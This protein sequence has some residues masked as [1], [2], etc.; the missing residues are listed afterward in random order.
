M[1]SSFPGAGVV[2]PPAPAPSDV[3]ALR[4][5]I[6]EHLAQNRELIAYHNRRAIRETER[7]LMEQTKGMHVPIALPFLKGKS[8]NVPI[9]FVLAPLVNMGRG[10]FSKQFSRQ[11]GQ[12]ERSNGAGES[13]GLELE[14]A[15]MLLPNM[16]ERVPDAELH[17]Y[18]GVIC[19]IAGDLARYL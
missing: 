1:D 2:T 10:M 7:G 16:L 17:Q 5:R 3:A 13:V 9:G 19:A 14:N 15:Y 4:R 18:V 12:I 6:L 8:V 11:S